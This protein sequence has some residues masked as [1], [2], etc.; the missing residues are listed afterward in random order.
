MNDFNKIRKGWIGLLVGGLLIVIDNIGRIQ[1]IQS[2]YRSFR[3]FL[4]SFHWP[5]H[6][7]T[8]I[9]FLAIAVGVAMY[10]WPSQKEDAA[11][12]E[13]YTGQIPNAAPHLVASTFSSELI[14][15][16]QKSVFVIHLRNDAVSPIATARNV[17]AH[18]GYRRQDRHAMHVDYGAWIEQT[19]TEVNIERGQTKRLVVALRDDDKNF[20]VNYTGPQTNFV[21]SKLISVGELT[22]GKWMMVVRINAENYQGVFYFSLTVEQNKA[23]KCDQIT[24]LLW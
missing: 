7:L 1:T 17:V 5:I 14:P 21:E 24:Q 9:G 19:G 11:E 18:I 23:I 12:G 22:A 4:P 3:E 15:F 20:A 6:L 13:S 16:L 10:W 8:Y 2:V